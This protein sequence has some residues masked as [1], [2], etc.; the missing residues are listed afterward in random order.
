MAARALETEIGGSQRTHLAKVKTERSSC[1][2]M[3]TL[4]D[5]FSCGV[6][7]RTSEASSR[8]SGQNRL[9]FP[10]NNYKRSLVRRQL[11]RHP[12]EHLET[13]GLKSRE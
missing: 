11:A 3:E 7:K 12:K 13:I 6:K 2:D 4:K 8:Q 10:C 9:G 1:D 5:G